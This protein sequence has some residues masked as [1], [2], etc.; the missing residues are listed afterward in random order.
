MVEK[1]NTSEPEP[2]TD[3]NAPAGAISRSGDEN[4][5]ANP[6]PEQIA[7]FKAQETMSRRLQVAF[8]EIVGLLMRTPQCKGMPLESLQELVV[9]AIRTGQ[10][11]VAESRVNNSGVITPVAAVLWA[12][13]SEKVDRRLSDDRGEPVKLAPED[14]KSGDIPWLILATGDKQV[15]KATQKRIEENVFNG[16]TLKTRF[17]GPQDKGITTP[18]LQSEAT[19]VE[20][21]SA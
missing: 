13:V 11:L 17:T 3:P 1:L 19:Q 16:R 21:A 10:F 4:A 20:G 12:S 6:S 2:Q 9:P 18:Q 7:K 5:G 15:I 14:W 8:G